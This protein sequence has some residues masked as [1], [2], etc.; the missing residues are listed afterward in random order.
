[1]L[2]KK[3]DESRRLL[4]KLWVRPM[5]IMMPLIF[6][7]WGDVTVGMYNDVCSESIVGLSVR[8]FTY[9]VDLLS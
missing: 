8:V 4:Y 3:S 9:L 7:I 2:A 5:I 6:Q 1:M